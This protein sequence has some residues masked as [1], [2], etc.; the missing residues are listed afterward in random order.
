VYASITLHIYHQK[1]SH[2]FPFVNALEIVD[3]DIGIRLR[4]ALARA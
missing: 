4:N 2:T 1:S 3:G